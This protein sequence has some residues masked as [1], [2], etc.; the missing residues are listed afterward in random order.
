MQQN[1]T[2]AIPSTIAFG[3][4]Y[5]FWMQ[6]CNV[7]L[8]PFD[9]RFP[10]TETTDILFGCCYLNPVLRG[11]SVGFFSQCC[12]LHDWSGTQSLQ[13]VQIGGTLPVYRIV[14]LLPDTYHIQRLLIPL[15]IMCPW[16]PMC[17]LTRASH[18]Y[19]QL[20]NTYYKKIWQCWLVLRVTLC[21]WI[22]WYAWNS[23]DPIA[24]QA[25]CHGVFALR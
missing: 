2:S 19:I 10:T 6:S 4:L 21:V 8:G 3:Q 14:W 25:A 23:P 1:H 7:T 9:Q 18:N 17:S 5:S 20:L 15:L 11:T 24:E 22:H 16:L 13:V 12:F